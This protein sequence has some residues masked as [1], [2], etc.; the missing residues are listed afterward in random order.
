[1]KNGEYGSHALFTCSLTNQIY[2]LNE[3]LSFILHY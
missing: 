1:M 2:I 3:V